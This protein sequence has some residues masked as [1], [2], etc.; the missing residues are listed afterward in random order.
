[1]PAWVQRGVETPV[2]GA[3]EKGLVT[4]IYLFIVHNFWLCTRCQQNCFAQVLS[5]ELLLKVSET[6]EH[7]SCP[8]VVAN[9]GNLILASELLNLEDKS[10]QVV[11]GHIGIGPIPNFFL[12]SLVVP[13]RLQLAVVA[14]SI[15]A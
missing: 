6:V 8:L 12:I 1:M 15:V 11:L 2:L 3:L 9:V 5:I 14:A 4:Q 13:R 7:L 10:W